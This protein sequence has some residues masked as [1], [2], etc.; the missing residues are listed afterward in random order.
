MH[1]NCGSEKTKHFF[2]LMFV[3]NK[4]I[5]NTYPPTNVYDVDSNISLKSDLPEQYID[6]NTQAISK[7]MYR[8]QYLQNR[9]PDLR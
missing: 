9:T 2:H 6:I 3:C 8:K 4:I 7:E 1:G 5:S